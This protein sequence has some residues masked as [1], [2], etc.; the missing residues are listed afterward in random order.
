MS[1]RDACRQRAS[2]YI[3]EMES[4]MSLIDPS[5]GISREDRDLASKKLRELKDRMASDTRPLRTGMGRAGLSWD[6]EQFLSALNEASTRILVATNS[7]P[8]R[9]PWY[10]QIYRACSDIKFYIQE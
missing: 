9:S 10:D 5:N 3:L 6:E 7:N 8:M 2:D 4:L 1:D